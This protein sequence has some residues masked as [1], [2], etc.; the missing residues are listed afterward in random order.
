MINVD[1]LKR[2]GLHGGRLVW[3]V[4]L[5]LLPVLGYSLWKMFTKIVSNLSE[6]EKEDVDIPFGYLDEYGTPE[7]TNITDA[8]WGAYYKK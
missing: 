7:Y 3:R 4:F 1:Y 5:I 8:Q 2:L 6:G